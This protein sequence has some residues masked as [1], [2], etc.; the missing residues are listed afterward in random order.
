[1]NH[2]LII[3]PISQTGQWTAWCRCGWTGTYQNTKP[4]AVAEGAVHTKGSR[5]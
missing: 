4:E 1:M 3:D 2:R 5:S